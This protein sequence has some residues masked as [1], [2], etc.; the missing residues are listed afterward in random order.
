MGN[1]GG[2]FVILWGLPTLLAFT[3]WWKY[4]QIQVS[5]RPPLLRI[6]M[7]SLMVSEFMLLLIGATVALATARLPVSL[8]TIGLANFCLCTLALLT[9]LITKIEHTARVWL[10]AASF[11]LMLFWLYSMLAH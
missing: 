6:G 2:A 11:Y 10:A 3:A 7:L 5:S 8:Q 9:A 4:R 1:R